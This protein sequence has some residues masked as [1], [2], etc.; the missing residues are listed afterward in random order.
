MKNAESPIEPEVVARRGLTVAEQARLDAW[1]AAHPRERERWEEETR[2]TALLSRLPPAPIS[3]NFTAR[4][5]G[6]VERAA[7]R[8]APAGIPRWRAWAATLRFGWT[9]ATA[10]LA[11]ALVLVVQH[12]HRVQT[13]LELA[14]S[15]A[16]LP[17]FG[18]ADTELWKD[19]SQIVTLPSTPPP[20]LD[21]LTA[22]MK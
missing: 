6:E 10:V 2:L 3:S 22:A 17:Q 7:T 16:T 21:E 20:S 8:P 9:T 4:V 1:L 18:L 19:F 12:Q 14:A 15:V 5:R 11:L 13:R